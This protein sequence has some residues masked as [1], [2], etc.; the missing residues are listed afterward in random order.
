MLF[1]SYSRG[2]PLPAAATFRRLQDPSLLRFLVDLRGETTTNAQ[3]RDDLMTMLVAGHETTAAVL[4]WALFQIAQNPE[5]LAK[6]RR[7]DQ[8]PEQRQTQ[9]FSL[10]LSFL[11]SFLTR[12][13]AGAPP[14]STPRSARSWTRC[15]RT[16]ASRTTTT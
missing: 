9:S 15:S 11:R 13:R 4:T 12:L 8:I 7:R 16:A 3:L 5:Y 14:T 6:A 2:Y 1:R 10:S